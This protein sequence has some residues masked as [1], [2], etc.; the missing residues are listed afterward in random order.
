MLNV[1]DSIWLQDYLKAL[2]KNSQSVSE[3]DFRQTVEQTREMSMEQFQ[4][5]FWD[6]VAKIPGTHNMSHVMIN[7][8][9]EGWERMKEDPEYR[10]KMMRL[11]RRDMTAPFCRQV[12][13][14]ITIGGTEEEYRAE[15]WSTGSDKKEVEDDMERRRQRRKYF[16]KRYEKQLEKRRLERKRLEIKRFE[17]YLLE[18]SMQER[19]RLELLYLEAVEDSLLYSQRWF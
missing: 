13:S 4:L 7:V 5:E 12:Y 15:S 16:Q 11:L 10:E 19:K 6:E 3:T 14:I 8:T 17:E 9:K 18:R 1:N 2:E